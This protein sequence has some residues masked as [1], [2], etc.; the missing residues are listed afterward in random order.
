MNLGEL[1]DFVGNLLDYD[2]TNSTYRSQLVSLLND[3]QGRLLT[4]RPWSFSIRERVLRVFTD[5]TSTA[6]FTNGTATVS[7]SFPSSSSSV[8]PGSNLDGALLFVTDSGG[9]TFEHSIAWV[10]NGT[11]LYLD[12]PFLGVTGAYTATIKRR[13]IFLPSDSMSVE[14]VG[15]PSVGIPAKA[16]FLSKFEREDANLDP[17]LLG[18]IEAY[19]PST[20][21][22]VPAPST[23]RGVATVA[24]GVSQG[25]RTINVYM[26]NVKGPD[27]TNFPVYPVEVSDGFESGLSKVATYSL[28]DAET[29]TFT[30]ETIDNTTGLYRRYYFTCPEA[31]ILA[32]VRIRSAGAGTTDVDTV[33]PT[34][35]VTLA[36]DLS[37]NTLSGQNFQS[38]SI[39]YQYNQSA[40]YQSIQLYPHPSGD[41]DIDVRLLLHPSR[42]Q[43][44]QDA[45][46][47]P[48]AYS[49]I[50][51]YAALENLTLKVDNPA[52]SAVYARKKD[53]LYQGMEQRY[54]AAV[55]R[56]IIKGTPTA[57]YRYVRNPFGKLTFTP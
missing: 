51:A 49:Q 40:G 28:G 35:G 5:T 52:L 43:E 24:S 23:V 1:I 55:P 22:V 30:P 25:V 32:P 20:G 39:R 31:N 42:L 17:D 26:C 33:A 57:G 21:M 6:T 44:D 12:R 27:A 38:K 10:E 8:R 50:I 19:L 7:G 15:D 11:T 9:N 2:P 34:G 48:A 56:R 37:L 54:L 14:N 3:A 53:V 47:V 29:L 4:D 45:P 18:T 41:Q 46:L 13:D 16:M 36:P